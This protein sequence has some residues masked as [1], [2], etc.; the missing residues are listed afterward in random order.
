MVA[1]TVESRGRGSS[2][3]QLTEMRAR[4]EIG[5][6]AAVAQHRYLTLEHDEEHVAHLTLAHDVGAGRHFDDV[7]VAG[8]D[9]KV[10]RCADAAKERDIPKLLDLQGSRNH[11]GARYCEWRGGNL[12]GR[13]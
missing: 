4:F 13:G 1:R 12:G 10:A 8:D 5:G 7:E 6:L 2:S 9:P 11:G 3:A